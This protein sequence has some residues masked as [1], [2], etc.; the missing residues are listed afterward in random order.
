MYRTPSVQLLQA[1]GH[2]SCNVQNT[3]TTAVT[4][5]MMATSLVM[6]RTPSV[7]LLQDDGHKSCIEH[8]QYNCYTQDNGHKSC[9][10]HHQ[11]SCYTQDDD[12]H[13]SCI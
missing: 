1:D 6:Y 3:I 2:K 4:H 13:K 12:D 11:Y 8:H 9:T 10:E 5:R 7:Q